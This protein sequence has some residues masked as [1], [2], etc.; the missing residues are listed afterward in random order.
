MA[1][2][3]KR[4]WRA[5]GK[6]HTAFQV[7]YRDQNGKR[8]HKQFDRKRDAD[9]FLVKILPEV[10]DGAHTPDR[11]SIT[12]AEASDLWLQRCEAKGFGRGTMATYRNLLPDLKPL[13]DK[14]LARLTMPGVEQYLDELM[15]SVTQKR[16]RRVLI[17]L[18]SIIKEAQR[19][20]L[21]AQNVAREVKIEI[22]NRDQGKIG[23]GVDVP[24]EEEVRTLIAHARGF[25][26][27]LLVTAVFTGTRSGEL[28]ALLWEDV[29]FERR[30][31]TVRQSA[32]AW[33]KIGPPKT[34]AGERV[35]PMV[36]TV[37]S[38]L[39]EWRLVC[40]RKGPRLGLHVA[41]RTAHKIAQFIEAH[42]ET[43]DRRRRWGRRY[44]EAIAQRLGVSQTAV[45]VVRQAMPLPPP[46]QI[47]LAFPG[48]EGVCGITPHSGAHFKTFRARSGWSVRTES[49]SIPCMISAIFLQ[50]WR[51]SRGISRQKSCRRFLVTPASR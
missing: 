45:C 36:P 50:A 7:D 42:P 23:I 2:I 21:V 5:G 29:D 46:G 44:L 20:G 4:T 10:R 8:R 11:G 30:V 39:R 31:I 12:V 35:I 27:P 28:R 22:S 3:R 43:A 34:R 32:D 13:Y 18:R 6:Q 48:R 25:L 15:K 38:T 49:Q 24:S 40:P 26:R 1:T 19:R 51:S 47:Y 37:V 9:E 33:G 17:V 41:E 16:A 14:K